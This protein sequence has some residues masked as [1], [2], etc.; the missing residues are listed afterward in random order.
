M[1]EGLPFDDRQDFDDAG[2][3][4][5]DTLDPGVIKASDGRIV[6]DSDAYAFLDGECPAT[7]HPSLWRHS[8]LCA[9]QGL[10][11]VTPGIYQVRGFDI[12]NMTLVEGDRGVI[13]IDPL[14]STECAAAALAIYRKH[15]GERPV[16]AVIYTHSHADHFGGVRGVVSE[17]VP[18]LAPEGFL[19]HAV[20]E[21]VYAGTAMARRS[22]YM[23][24]PLLEKGPSGQIGTGL[25]LTTSTGTVS[26][27]PP[28]V[29][30]TRTGQEEVLDACGSGS[31]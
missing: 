9:R 20:A 16:S 11:E 25:G 8:Q 22:V 5:I 14:I 1:S 24:G 27:L 17:D 26:L 3:G 2:R 19:E 12:S 23:Y 29:D 18:I 21:N 4:L 6:W 31:R 28:T 15:R 30:I 13:V 7:A 10:F